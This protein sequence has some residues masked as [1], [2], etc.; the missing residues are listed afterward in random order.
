MQEAENYC[1]VISK[2]KKYLFDKTFTR[3]LFN[4]KK[5]LEKVL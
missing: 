1:D 3:S 4:L 5:A 2:L